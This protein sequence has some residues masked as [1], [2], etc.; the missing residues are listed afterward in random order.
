[1]HSGTRAAA[2]V[3]L[4]F[5]LTL[6]ASGALAIFALDYYEY[7]LGRWA[8][9]QVYVWIATAMSLVVMLASS[10][11]FRFNSKHA[12][13]PPPLT[14]TLIG[15]L[16]VI[17]FWLLAFLLPQQLEGRPA[18]VAVFVALVTFALSVGV[19]RGRRGAV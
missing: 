4:G 11:G 16:I 7:G 19:S 14:A 2:L 8:S 12:A 13:P 18:I 10:L 17:S 9:L 1:M 5:W 6:V 15:A 3:T